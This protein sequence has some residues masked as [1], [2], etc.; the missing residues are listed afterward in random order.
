MKDIYDAIMR[1]QGIQ[2]DRPALGVEAIKAAG[3]AIFAQIDT[4]K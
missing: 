3:E 2:F 1:F 4:H